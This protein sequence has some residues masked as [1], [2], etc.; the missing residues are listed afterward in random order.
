MKVALLTAAAL[1]T[2]L[3]LS[4]CAG[5]SLNTPSASASA[6]ASPSTPASAASASPAAVSSSPATMPP[7]AQANAAAPDAA[8]AMPAE[9]KGHFNGD[10]AQGTAADS[11]VILELAKQWH[12]AEKEA[13]FHEKMDS[14]GLSSHVPPEQAEIWFGQAAVACQR[15]FDGYTPPLEGVW[16][17]IEYLALGEYCPE[18]R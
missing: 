2:V 10:H 18:L 5:Q 17:D 8:P 16:K 12:S 11:A 14:T 9:S 1:I 3:G 13:L 4:G 6:L 7:P 15:R